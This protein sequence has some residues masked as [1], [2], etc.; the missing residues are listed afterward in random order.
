MI[1]IEQQLKTRPMHITTTGELSE[2]ESDVFV[3]DELQITF[4]AL[5]FSGY[6]V[7]IDYKAYSKGFNVIYVD[8]GK[9]PVKRVNDDI[10]EAL[11]MVG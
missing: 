6:H 7:S 9:S 1:M 4:Y 3:P 8:H 10:L 11:E 5:M 2:F